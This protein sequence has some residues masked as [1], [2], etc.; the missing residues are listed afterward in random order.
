LLT[1]IVRSRLF[2]R[3]GQAGYF[4]TSLSLIWPPAFVSAHL[5]SLSIVNPAQLIAAL[6]EIGPVV[7]VTPLVAVWCIRSFRVG[8]WPE[9][10]LLCAS[11]ASV[12]ALFMQFKGPLFTAW[13]RLM[14][15]WFF[16]CALYAV[17]LLWARARANDGKIQTLT[18]VC[19]SAAC[20]SGL[21]L[22]GI[23]LLAIQRPTLATFIT[24]L[25][26]K[27]SQEYWNKLNVEAVVFDPVVYRAPTV[28]GRFTDSS[29]SWYTKDANWQALVAAPDPRALHAAG[30]DY[31]YFDK[32]YWDG[33]TQAQQSSLTAPCVKQVAQVDGN[34]SEQNYAKDFRR[35]L[36]ISACQ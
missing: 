17:P 22:F 28:F 21:V 15:G 33:L 24:P 29:P 10:A 7:F 9:V 34:H 5:G 4:D 26:A 1:E 35:L 23:Q 13:P 2:S 20:L 25:D 19:V 8:R 31:M 14:G 12:L 16:A 18:V 36:D 11:L 3:S 32:D 30:F 6:A 27:M